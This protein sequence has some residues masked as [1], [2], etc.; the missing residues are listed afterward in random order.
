MSNLPI[1]YSGPFLILYISEEL[2]TKDKQEKDGKSCLCACYIYHPHGVCG[3]LL[4]RELL[5]GILKV[6]MLDM[7]GQT[8]ESNCSSLLPNGNMEL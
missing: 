3:V 8:E 6:H 4:H 7:C 1:G 5:D 2:Q